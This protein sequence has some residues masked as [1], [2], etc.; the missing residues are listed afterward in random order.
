M[1]GIRVPLFIIAIF[2]F[3]ITTA[4]QA[5]V[6]F[7]GKMLHFP[8]KE[9]ISPADISNVQF[10]LSGIPADKQ[11]VVGKVY[12]AQF[13]REKH[14]RNQGAAVLGG[15]KYAVFTKWNAN[16]VEIF[17]WKYPN[18]F[19]D[20]VPDNDKYK[21]TMRGSK[22]G[23]FLVLSFKDQ[24]INLALGAGQSQADLEAVGEISIPA[25]EAQKNP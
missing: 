18:P 15:A 13:A 12:R 19:L 7:D 3:S 4:A 22:T 8:E 23:N 6:T 1:R 24:L 16:G 20:C 5:Q 14:G 21:C 2:V 25:S 11:F 17:Y 10:D 9:G